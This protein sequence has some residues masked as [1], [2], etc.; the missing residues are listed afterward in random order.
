[1][2]RAAASVA[3]ASL[4]RNLTFTVYRVAAGISM[5]GVE[6]S[7]GV[8]V[9]ARDCDVLALFGG[10]R[11]GRNRGATAKILRRVERQ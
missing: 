7:G 2:R 10:E 6:V 3:L 9:R 1:M 4:K 11:V 8:R 5:R